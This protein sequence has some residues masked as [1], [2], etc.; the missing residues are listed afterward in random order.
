VLAARSDAPFLDTLERD[1]VCFV[2]RLD[3]SQDEAARRVGTPSRGRHLADDEDLNR[4]VWKAHDELVRPQR[5]ADLVID[6]SATGPVDAARL[7]A[8]M[9]DPDSQPG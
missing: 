8:E 9:I 4:Q 7:I 5:H 6:T 2:A 1:G 3:V